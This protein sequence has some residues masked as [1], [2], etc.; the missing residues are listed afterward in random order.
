MIIAGVD[1]VGR[2]AIFGNVVSSAVILKK[3]INIEGLNDSKKINSNKRFIVFKKIIMQSISI[4]IGYATNYEIDK[5][6]ILKATLLSMKRA[7]YALTISPD[8][9]LI[10][11]IHCPDVSYKCKTIIKGDNLVNEIKAASIVAKIIRDYEILNISN[12]YN[13]FNLIKNKGY[14]TKK[15][16]FAISNFGFTHFHRKTFSPIK[17]IIHNEP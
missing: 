14:P 15:H 9:I 16:I 3:N 10:D 5:I 11:G 1:E 17:D 4:G 12:I 7:I 13:N 2:G 6:N 8:L